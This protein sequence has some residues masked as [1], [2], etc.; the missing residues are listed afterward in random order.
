VRK[1]RRRAGNAEAGGKGRTKT[2]MKTSNSTFPILTHRLTDRSQL[3][4]IAE[5]QED[6]SCD[7]AG[8]DHSQ[9]QPNAVDILAQICRETIGNMLDH[10]SLNATKSDRQAFKNKRSAFEAFGQDLEDE[11]FEMSEAVETRI[12]LEARVRKSKREKSDLQAQWTVVRREREQ[13]ALQCD[14]V[15]KRH[16]ETEEDAREKWEVGEAVRKVELDLEIGDERHKDG[17]DFLLQSVVEDVS[18]LSG[19]GGILARFREFNLMLENI[20]M[21]L[22][23]SSV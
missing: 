7:E 2:K 18:C 8:Q 20:A 12:N 9:R 16:W 13:I 10:M 21:A 1:P 4:T 17:S 5:E 15:R 19:Q 3:S 6:G 11:L 14:G 22:E 23:G